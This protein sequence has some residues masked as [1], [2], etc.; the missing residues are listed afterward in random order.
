MGGGSNEFVLALPAHFHRFQG[1]PYE[2]PADEKE[3]CDS[4]KIEQQEAGALILQQDD[5]RR[6]VSQESQALVTPGGGKDKDCAI[7]GVFLLPGHREDRT[8]DYRGGD[9][10]NCRID[11]FLQSFFTCQIDERLPVRGRDPGTGIKEGFPVLLNMYDQLFRRLSLSQPAS[12]NGGA[13]LH[14]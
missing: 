9:G 11:F 8:L 4:Q 14:P 13:V 5:A 6:A 2:I 7:V 1:F 12:G 10:A 3:G